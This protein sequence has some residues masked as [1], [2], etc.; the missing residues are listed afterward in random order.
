M[1]LLWAIP[2][3]AVT[4][5]MLIALI[6]L[7]SIDDATAD[8]TAH[9]QRVDEIRVAVADVRA[10]AAEARATARGLRLR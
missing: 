9:L 6:Q 3:V 7:R 10:A 4:V 8:L 2:P 1:S 5:A